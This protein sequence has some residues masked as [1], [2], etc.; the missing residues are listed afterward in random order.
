M[1]SIDSSFRAAFLAAAVFGCA[2]GAA[3]AADTQAAWEGIMENTA[4][5]GCTGVGGA[6]VGDNH[7]SI[8]RPHINPTDTA[9]Y[10]AIVFTR[11]EFTLQNFSETANFQM[12]GNGKYTATVI[13]G[14]GEPGTYS[15]TFSGI[16]VT[17]KPISKGYTGPV[18]IIGTIDNYFNVSGCDVTF[19]ATY[20]I[21]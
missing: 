10:L 5:P 8:Y 11:A 13:D 15:G 12:N 7:V 3:G 14:R 1:M 20:G 16:V 17:P 18:T 9:T 6:A 2:S 19:K 21:E 4:A